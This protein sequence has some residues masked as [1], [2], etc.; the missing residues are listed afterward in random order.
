ML[1]LFLW[2]SGM[3]MIILLQIH[4]L[5]ARDALTQTFPLQQVDELQNMSR[6]TG[7]GKKQRAEED[8]APEHTKIN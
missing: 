7:S 2:A 8:G 5:T 6:H 1:E 3:Y 4:R